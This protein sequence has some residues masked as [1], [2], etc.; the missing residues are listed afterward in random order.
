[1]KSILSAL[2]ATSL[3]VGCGNSNHSQTLKVDSSSER[4][5]PEVGPRV[6][7]AQCWGN[8]KGELVEGSDQYTFN[9]LDH[10]VIGS[11]LS[12][13]CDLSI[14]IGG[15][16]GYRIKIA[17]RFAQ[18]EYE[19][20]GREYVSVGILNRRSQSSPALAIYKD[21]IHTID[22]VVTELSGWKLEP[23]EASDISVGKFS[24]FETV[25][26]LSSCGGALFINNQAAIMVSRSEPGQARIQVNS[27]SY[28]KPTLEKC[29]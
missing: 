24:G 15:V 12:N 23:N 10:V 21:G 17:T 1:M 6:W 28:S 9:F 18:G 27:I 2:L 19:N 11:D 7:A 16:A 25:D 8:T 26:Y 4:N 20:K 5:L 3:V 13:V 22:G 14:A 29:D